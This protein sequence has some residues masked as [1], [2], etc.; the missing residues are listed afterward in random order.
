MGDI[1]AT[2]ENIQDL[3]TV[4]IV[5]SVPFLTQMRMVNHNSS[6]LQSEQAVPA[7]TFD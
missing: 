7:E 4:V 2:L 6:K 1:F 3:G 5:M